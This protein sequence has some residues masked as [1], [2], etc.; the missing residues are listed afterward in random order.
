MVGSDCKANSFTNN[1]FACIRL[2]IE[3]PPASAC[4]TSVFVRSV[5]ARVLHKDWV[6]CVFMQNMVYLGQVTDT[7]HQK[8]HE[9]AT[10]AAHC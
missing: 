4:D 3:G 1:H 2:R 6:P 7:G 9:Q 5:G 10:T 8:H